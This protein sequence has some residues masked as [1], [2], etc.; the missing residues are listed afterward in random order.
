MTGHATDPQIEQELIGVA[1]RFA[2]EELRP[3]AARFDETEEYPS[4]LIRKAAA[5]GLTCYDLPEAYGGG[6]VESLRT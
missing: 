3:V 6:G 5:I 1:H 4:E 2:E